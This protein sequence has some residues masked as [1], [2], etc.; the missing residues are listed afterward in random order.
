MDRAIVYAFDN[1]ESKV[2]DANEVICTQKEG[3]GVRLDYNLERSRFS[4]VECEQKLVVAH[5][6]KDNVYFRHMPNSDNCILK[7]SKFKVD[8]FSCYRDMAYAREG[9]RHKDLKHKIGEFLKLEVGVDNSSIDVDS[10]FIRGK[11][12]DKRRPDVYCEYEGKK[13]AFE[14]QISYLPLHYIQHR[15]DFY[16][17]N[18][19]YLIWILDFRNSPK[20]LHTFQRDIKYIWKHQN[21]FM[22]DE[23]QDLN[24]RLDCHF[25]QP[26]IFNNNEVHEKWINRDARLSDLNFNDEDYSCYFLHYEVEHTTFTKMLCAIKEEAKRKHEEEKAKARKALVKEE[27]TDLLN[28]I[29]R[30]RKLDYNFYSLAQQVNG[31]EDDSIEE[32]NGRVDLNRRTKDGTP[33]FL[34]YIEEYRNLNDDYGM[35]VA[36]FLLSCDNFKFDINAR[37]KDGNGIIQYL[38]KNVDLERSFYK[39][40][41][42]LF[43]RS[44]KLQPSDEKFLV[45]RDGK[46]GL[47]DYLELTYLSVC[48]TSEEREIVRK[49]LRFLWFV[50]SAQR[51]EIIGANFKSWVQYTVS[52]LSNYKEYLSFIK[53]VLNNTGLGKELNR[54][55]KKGTV[56]KK[57]KEYSESFERSDNEIF[58]VLV[59]AY[60]EI[61]I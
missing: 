60:P 15:Y 44:Y 8:L 23:S 39:V 55:D 27:V 12:G 20:D 7:D 49:M 4:C 61:F 22:L 50:E 9:D 6:G 25:K 32:L 40:K 46:G 3:F 21:L 56:R 14:I 2:V 30:Y 10:T 29:S 36:E 5:S 18:G 35:T 33:L 16:K 45:D 54:V 48:F 42:Y 24:L 13:I 51:M 41:N 1:E 17:A 34:I 11:N 26:F 19:I 37:D 31:L 43:D 59:K 47:K 52:I 38:L 58:N 57:I 53:D 28:K